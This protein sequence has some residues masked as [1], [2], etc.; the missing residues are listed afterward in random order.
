MQCLV[1]LARASGSYRLKPLAEVVLLGQPCAD[2][3]VERSIDRRR[4]DRNALSPRAAPLL[5]PTDARR[6]E[7]TVSATARRC[8]VAGRLCSAR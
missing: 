1:R 8:C 7:N 4:A 3:E 6:R 5:R 2:Q